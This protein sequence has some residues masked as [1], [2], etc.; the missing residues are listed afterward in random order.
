MT[1]P[2]M[3]T[4]TAGFAVQLQSLR[5]RTTIESDKENEPTTYHKPY[6]LNLLIKHWLKLGFYETIN[7]SSTVAVNKN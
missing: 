1:L 4:Q 5:E 2:W 6:K 3:K 7:Y